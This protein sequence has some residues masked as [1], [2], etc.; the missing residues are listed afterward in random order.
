M[1]TDLI[2]KYFSQTLFTFPGEYTKNDFTIDINF[3]SQWVSNAV[4]TVASGMTS[5]K[6]KGSLKHYKF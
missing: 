3:Q 4:N 2:V 6:S 5:F 1:K